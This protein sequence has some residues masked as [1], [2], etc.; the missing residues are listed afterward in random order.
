[1]LSGGGRR[2]AYY[3]VDV[4][5]RGW[6]KGLIVE[7]GHLGLG[8]HT[9]A[10]FLRWKGIGWEIGYGNDHVFPEKMLMGLLVAKWA[11]RMQG[12]PGPL[13]LNLTEGPGCCHGNFRLRGSTSRTSSTSRRMREEVV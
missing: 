9:G 7:E 13:E 6:I 5:L 4:I 10:G 12:A 2:R 1:M 11:V 3:F 8:N